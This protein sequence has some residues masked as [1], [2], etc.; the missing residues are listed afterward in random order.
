MNRTVEDAHLG[1]A[2]IEVGLDTRRARP[3]SP[4]QHSMWLLPPT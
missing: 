2:D 1:V 4:R 3:A